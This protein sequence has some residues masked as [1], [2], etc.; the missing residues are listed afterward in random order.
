[1]ETIVYEQQGH[2]GWLRLNRP[3]RLNAM[4]LQMWQELAEIGSRLRDDRSIRALVVIGNGRSFSSGIDL[5]SFS[6]G[7]TLFTEAGSQAR[8]A[9]LPVEDKL[10]ATI[11]EI[12]QAYKWLAEAPFPTIAAVRGHALGGGAQLALACDLRVFARGTSFGLFE[13]KY[14]LVPDLGGMY[15]LPRL[16]GTAKAKELIWTSAAI[17]ADEADRIGLVN[18]L[19]DDA[20][21]ESTVTALAEQVAAFPPLAVSGAKRAIDKAPGQTL[22]EGLLEAAVEQAVCIRAKDF[23]EAMSALMEKRAPTYQGE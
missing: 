14:G 12:Q 15:W 4:T 6:G 3:D 1:M 5:N 11:T 16:V 10:V 19:V 7:G 2:I 17:D 22:T 23:L 18:R 13:H 8:P 20:D 21:L 9:S